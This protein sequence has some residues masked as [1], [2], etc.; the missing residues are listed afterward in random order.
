MKRSIFVLTMAVLGSLPTISSAQYFEGREEAIRT[1]KPHVVFLDCPVREVKGAVTS[2]AKTLPGYEGPC[3]IVAYPKN[4]TTYFSSQLPP[5]VVEVSVVEN[6]APSAAVRREKDA[7][8]EVNEVRVRRGLRPFIH[9]DGLCQAACAAAEYRAAR[10]IAGHCNDFAFLPQGCSASAAGCAAWPP[11][12]G[13]GACCTYD[14]Y[15]HAGA[16]VAIG[17]DGQRYM[18]LFVR[19]G[20][21][22]GSSM[23]VPMSSGRGGRRR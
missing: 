6:L 16:A 12:M 1:N 21:G 20:D 3:I 14:N 23:S 18:H 9:D 7:L 22:G 5:D 15:T 10:C 19:G 2:Y 11:D 17:P 4:G 13:W 8:R